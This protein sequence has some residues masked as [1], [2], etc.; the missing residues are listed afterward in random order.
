MN[1]VYGRYERMVR[2]Q[3]ERLEAGLSNLPAMIDTLEKF[4]NG[5]VV[6]HRA[7]Y[8]A[9]RQ[10]LALLTLPAL[11]CLTGKYTPKEFWRKEPIAELITKCKTRLKNNESVK[12]IY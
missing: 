12:R 6:S 10:I 2:S 4:A 9:M 1:I 7:V 3:I 11:P 5:D 8:V